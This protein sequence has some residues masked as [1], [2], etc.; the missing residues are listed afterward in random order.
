MWALLKLQWDKNQFNSTREIL[1]TK[2]TKYYHSLCSTEVLKKWYTPPAQG[3]GKRYSKKWLWLMCALIG[4]LKERHFGVQNCSENRYYCWTDHTVQHSKKL[5]YAA[6]ERKGKK[7]K[8]QFVPDALGEVLRISLS[9]W[10]RSLYLPRN[11]AF[12]KKIDIYT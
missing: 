10:L 2:T 12:L 9:L 8:K 5:L 3:R 7:K 6:S 1:F 11:I 4:K